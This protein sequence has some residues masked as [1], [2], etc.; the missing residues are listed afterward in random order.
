MADGRQV[1]RSIFGYNSKK[2]YPI[3]AKFYT[4][5]QNQFIMTVKCHKNLNFQFKMADGFAPKRYTN[6]DETIYC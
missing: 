5:M 2:V 4:K 3:C 1:G 6:A